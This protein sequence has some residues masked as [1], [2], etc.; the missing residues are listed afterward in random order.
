MSAITKAYHETLWLMRYDI[1]K[2]SATKETGRAF[3]IIK[4]I[5]HYLRSYHKFLCSRF[6]DDLYHN[7]EAYADSPLFF[8]LRDNAESRDR[9]HCGL[10]EMIDDWDAV[11]YYWKLIISMKLHAI[12]YRAKLSR[13]T[14]PKSVRL[15][16]GDPEDLAYYAPSPTLDLRSG[17]SEETVRDFLFQFLAI[18]NEVDPV[19]IDARMDPYF[20]ATGLSEEG[21]KHRGKPITSTDREFELFDFVMDLQTAMG[22]ELKEDRI[23]LA[24]LYE[25]ETMEGFYDVWI[26]HLKHEGLLEE[27]RLAMFNSRGGR[28]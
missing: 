11:F 18:A 19:N 6:C 26:D 12:R 20:V 4:S 2:I 27:D 9:K 21:I 8:E 22:V 23:F 10:I 16:Y 13:L 28:S 14:E 15:L 24:K 17:P 1:Q 5:V 25:S 7:D 3:K